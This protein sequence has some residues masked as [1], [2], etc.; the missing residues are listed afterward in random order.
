MKKINMNSFYYKVSILFSTITIVN[1]YT[2]GY[3]IELTEL[4]VYA[5]TS[6]SPIERAEALIGLLAEEVKT[7][8][9]PYGVYGDDMIDHDYVV[10]QIALSISHVAKESREAR[11]WLILKLNHS[12][13]GDFQ[14]VLQIALGLS[15]DSSVAD[16]LVSI[17]NQDDNYHLRAL[18]AN[19]LGKCGAVLSIPD[20]A[21]ALTDSASYETY[22]KHGIQGGEFFPVR[23]AARLA[24]KTLGVSVNNPDPN[25]IFEYEI[26]TSSAVNA[27]QP[28]LESL[29]QKIVLDALRAI[30]RLG[31][32]SAD[33]ALKEFIDRNR[34]SAERV[35]LV[36]E[37]QNLIENRT[38]G[39]KV[40]T[41]NGD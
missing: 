8:T 9:Q 15:G 35:S 34:Q 14:P 13:S 27:I 20:L 16:G 10:A 41:E 12:K 19:A 33:E 7:P 4:Q 25:N 26:D 30:D 24:L 29:D 36:I 23:L 3:A 40:S 32:N 37:A 6:K 1:F 38:G 21:D 11:Q 5:D 39:E 17:L 18:A 28:I 31:G 2:F 22:E